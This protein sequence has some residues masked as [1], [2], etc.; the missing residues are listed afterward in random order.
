[1]AKRIIG[2]IPARLESVRLPRKPLLPILGHPMIAWVYA[3][4]RA[5]RLL[6]QL[7]VATDSDE[8][9]EWC[10]SLRIPAAITS[11]AHHSGTE[12]VFEVMTR[13]SRDGERGDIYVNI[14]CDEPLVEAEHIEKLLSPLLESASTEVSTL[15][16]PLDPR[17]AASPHKV[18]VVIDG[19]GRALYF[20]RSMIPYSVE[21]ESPAA[22]FKH[23]GLYAYSAAALEKFRHLPPGPLER[24]EKLEQLRF[25]ENGIAVAVPATSKDTIGI[26]TAED[27]RAVEEYFK[28]SGIEFPEIS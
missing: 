20:S 24:A 22:L 27:L 18:K 4:A 16:V 26:D 8:V 12:R 2:V 1:M 17:D 28:R 3:R 7:L 9:L 11:P 10:R 6:T 19:K 25:L 13:Q 21:A 23:L 5:A 14:Q 15:R